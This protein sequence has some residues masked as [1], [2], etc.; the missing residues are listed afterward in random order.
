MKVAFIYPSRETATV[1]YRMSL[2][3]R[4]FTKVEPV[5]YNVSSSLE[6][7]DLE[8]FLSTIKEDIVV[9]HRTSEFNALT[10]SFLTKIL[11]KTVVFDTDDYEY[12]LPNV[13]HLKGAYPKAATKMLMT[14]IMN[15]SSEIWVTTRSLKKALKRDTSNPV[16]VI[17]NSP[18]IFEPQWNVPHSNGRDTLTIGWVGGVSHLYDLPVCAKGIRDLWRSGRKFHLKLCGMPFKQ[19]ELINVQ[20][21]TIQ[22]PVDKEKSFETRVRA[23]FDFLPAENISLHK[24]LPLEEYASFYNDIDIVI[25]PLEDHSFNDCKSELKILEAGFKKLPIIV[26]N[27][28]SYATFPRDVIEL[29]SYHS[30]WGKSLVKIFDYSEDKRQR[31]GRALYDYVMD[32]FNLSYWAHY[33]EERLLNL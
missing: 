14:E 24:G 7:T 2:P 32:R 19:V 17:P 30:S 26:S 18:D 11:N 28:R 20:G 13:H 6:K 12:N 8:E 31:M 10:V 15:A 16:E 27:V 21:S 25:A 5:I 4:Y 9:V 1:Y 33:R 3:I 29:V 22:K 23:I